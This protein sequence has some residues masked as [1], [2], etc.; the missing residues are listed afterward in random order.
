MI[1]GKGFN[2]SDAVD[3][4]LATQKEEKCFIEVRERELNHSFIRIYIIVCN[5]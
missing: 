4:T 3:G 5:K 2:C 1:K